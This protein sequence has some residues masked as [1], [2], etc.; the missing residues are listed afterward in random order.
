MSRNHRTYLEMAKI[1]IW[2]IALLGLLWSS[3]KALAQEEQDTTLLNR[4]VFPAPSERFYNVRMKLSSLGIGGV[5]LNDDYLSPL[6]YGGLGVSYTNESS[7]LRYRSLS[8]QVP[9]TQRLLGNMPRVTSTR[10]LSQRHF[11]LTLGQSKNPAG[12][13]TIS[14]LQARLSGSRQY[15]LYAGEWGRVYLGPGYTIGGGGLYSSRN[16]NNPATLKVDA[17]FGLA[18]SYSYRLP[19]ESFPALIR[20]SSRTDILGVQWGQEYGES[21]YEL[22]YLSKAWTKR[23]ALSYLGKSWGQELRLNIDLPLWDRVVYNIGYRFHHK[24]WTHSNLYNRM[25]EHT[26]S[27]GITRYLRPIGG[28]QWQ[29]T[30]K[31]SVPF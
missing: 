8:D 29:H 11:V 24:S 20:L 19:W 16:G 6:R 4:G 22:Y 3:P 28:R 12:N 9:L 21:Y 30:Q 18:L 17:S 1:R 25:S 5:I 10:W 7:Q 23:F 2:C 31:Q 14:H 27:L 26:L 15:R 13:A